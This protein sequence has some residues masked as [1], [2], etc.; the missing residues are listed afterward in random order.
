LRATA[1]DCATYNKVA[2]GGS[3]APGWATI[4]DIR[5]WDDIDEHQGGSAGS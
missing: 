5:G 2:L 1:K 3:G 4:N